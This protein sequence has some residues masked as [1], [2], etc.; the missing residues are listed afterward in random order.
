MRNKNRHER[1]RVFKE[2]ALRKSRRRNKKFNWGQN[3][4]SRRLANKY[5]LE[6]KKAWED[7]VE[8]ESRKRDK[9]GRRN[10]RKVTRDWKLFSK[11]SFRKKNKIELTRG[12]EWFLIRPR[13]WF[14][15]GVD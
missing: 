14:W 8:E 7:W 3:W 10:H 1:N 6:G 11:R 5:D 2:N 4:E 9:G 15:D 12:R 13:N